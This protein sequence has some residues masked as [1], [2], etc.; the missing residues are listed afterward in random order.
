M[1]PQ[2]T[3]PHNRGIVTAH[4]H[5]PK[6]RVENRHL[7]IEDG[8]GQHRRVRR[9]HRTDRLRRLVLVGRSGY[10]TL[11]AI[12]WLH[13]SGAAFLHVD[14]TGELIAAT[15]SVGADLAGL[16]RA[17][18]LPLGGPAG[19]EVARRVPAL[20]VAGQRALLDDLPGGALAEIRE[21]VEWALSEIEAADDLE[22]L[23]SSWTTGD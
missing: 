16:R 11:D 23:S 21:R 5:G 4:G 12:R 10:V 13:D 6:V 2:N 8:F 3:L 22:P 18:A 14:A 17:Q 15:V 9:F 19:L 20:K 1:R 7:I